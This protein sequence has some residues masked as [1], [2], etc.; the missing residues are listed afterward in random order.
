MEEHDQQKKDQGKK[1]GGQDLAEDFDDD[2]DLDPWNLADGK[3]ADKGAKYQEDKPKE[4]EE[5]KGNPLNQE[6]QPAFADLEDIGFDLN[7]QDQKAD[8]DEGKNQELE[9]KVKK[10]N[11]SDNGLIAGDDFGDDFDDDY[12]DDDDYINEMAKHEKKE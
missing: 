4:K 12:E 6:V 5:P 8:A 1:N 10:G 9:K 2:Y 11:D 3:K 7:D